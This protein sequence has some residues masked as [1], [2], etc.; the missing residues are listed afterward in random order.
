MDGG[1]VGFDNV[2]LDAAAVPEPS[3][4]TLFAS[5]LLGLLAYAWRKRK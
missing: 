4:L 5:G 1:H 2:T 3:L